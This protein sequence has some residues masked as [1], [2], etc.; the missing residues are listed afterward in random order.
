MGKLKFGDVGLGLE[1]TWG[2]AASEPIAH[3][4]DWNKH[5]G[6]VTIELTDYGRE[7]FT[8]ALHPRTATMVL[9]E[10]AMATVRKQPAGCTVEFGGTKWRVYRRNYKLNKLYLKEAVL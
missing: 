10:R 6:D 9:D 3:F 5:S 1:S 7:F 4:I 8:S 2:H